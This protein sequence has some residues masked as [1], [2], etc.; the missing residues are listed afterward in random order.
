MK[1]KI[2]LA[3]HFLNLA[4]H[5]S[6]RIQ[7]RAL[8]RG[9]L[10]DQSRPQQR[11]LFPASHLRDTRVPEHR[12]RHCEETGGYKIKRGVGGNCCAFAPFLPE[13]AQHLGGER[14]RRGFVVRQN[15]EVRTFPGD[16]EVRVELD[17]R[18]HRHLLG[19]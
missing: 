19:C 2:R 5:P 17:D 3:D 13:I 6:Q 10:A 18:S 12:A 7:G 15:R 11:W 1:G 14:R 9:R 4:N 16:W 8:V